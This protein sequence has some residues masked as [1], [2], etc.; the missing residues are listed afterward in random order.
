MEASV[1][2][3][4][5]QV[6][7]PKKIRTM[8]HIKKGTQVRFEPRNGEIVLKPLTPEYFEKMAGILGTGR[9]ATKALLEERAKDR[10][11]ENR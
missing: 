1:V 7:I 8:F 4:K 11:R 5:G 9:K 2:T 3:F 10:E 6:V